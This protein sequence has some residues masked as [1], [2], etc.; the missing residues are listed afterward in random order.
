MLPHRSP[1]R[2]R[3][4][5]LLVLL[6]CAAAAA[7]S[8]TVHL[9]GPEGALVRMNG[10]DL[11]LL[12]FDAPLELPAGVFE[13]ECRIR[14]HEQFTK[15]IVISDRDQWLH[16]RLRPIPLTRGRAV[17]GSAIYAGL[18]QWYMGA[19]V[20]GWVYFL[21]ETG[22]LLTALAG[23]LQRSNYSDDYTNYQAK[24]DSA[25]VDEE[26][27]YWKQQ[28]QQA[29]S[30]MEDMESLRNTGLYVALGSYVVSLLD[31]WLLFPSVDIGPGTLP[32]T[33]TSLAP[34]NFRSGAHAAVVID[35]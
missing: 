2:L 8:A 34:L 4:L 25:I 20:R 19:T 5:V 23:E 9:S 6:L 7:Q 13:F 1:P 3:A 31:A 12:P 10:Q 35:F 24:Y 26:I 32:P 21:G 33:E 11:G 17:A 16:V 18:G 27:A 15:V 29:Y 30:N 14:G 28:S 22:G